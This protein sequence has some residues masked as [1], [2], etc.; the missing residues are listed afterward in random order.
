MSLRDNVLRDRYLQRGE[1]EL[2]MYERV[3]RTLANTDE[4][5]VN[6]KRLM[7]DRLFFPNSPTLVNA[8]TGNEGGFSACY[9]VPVEDSLDSIFKGMW[10][11]GRIHKYFGGTGFN[12]SEVRPRGSPIKSTGGRA[13]GPV[14]VL[15]SYNQA[16]DMV[17]QGGKRQGANMGILNVDHPDL[18][19]FIQLKEVY[20]DVNHFN[21]SVGMSNEFMT[22]IVEDE[23]DEV[24]P[25]DGGMSVGDIWNSIT[26]MAWKSGD[27]GLIYLDTMNETHPCGNVGRI[28]S[29]NPCGEIGLLPYESCNLGSINLSNMVVDE[30]FDYNL[31]GDVIEWAVR[32]LDNIID[33]NRYPIEEVAIAT[34]LTRKIGLGVMGWHDCLIKMGIPYCSEEALD[35]CMKIGRY[36]QTVG[37]RTSCALADNRG[38]FPAYKGSVWDDLKYPIRN[39]TV[40]AIAPTGTLST[41]FAECS[42][43][44]EPHFAK[45]FTRESESGIGTYRVSVPEGET[46][47]EIP[48]E[49][50]IKHQ[51][52]W[53]KWIHNAVSKTINM[54]SSVSVEDVEQA[55]LMAWEL[56]CKGITV[57]RDGCKDQQ[58]LRTVNSEVGVGR[59][60][61]GSTKD[62][63]TGCGSIHVTCNEMEGRPYEVYVLS[64]GGCPANNEALGKVISKY[65]HDPRLVG[66]EVETVGRITKTLHKVRCMTAMKSGKA[67]GKSCADIIAGRMDEVWAD[68]NI[69]DQK[70]VCPECKKPLVFA[71]GCGNGECPHCGWSGCS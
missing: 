11:A 27:P 24:W 35:A 40:T 69:V 30:D 31:F 20:P 26:S 23:L 50:H 9:V 3:A 70:P 61:F 47:M 18:M 68:E 42:S 60:R 12:F 10:H 52:A 29:T 34:L 54:P 4:E 46:A 21:I 57:Y 51:A 28:D 2:D 53:Q 7:V 66:G 63:V 13:C 17:S 37:E 59:E 67:A 8:G 62:F 49:W 71:G 16:A 14:S 19:E 6:F 38:V 65:L 45:E 39:G 44:I 55:Y 32:M 43:G 15:R 25:S 41:I 36:L 56:G 1:T 48:Y 64:E 22:K 33:K 5:Y 58:V